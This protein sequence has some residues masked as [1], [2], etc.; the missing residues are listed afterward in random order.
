MLS[1][2]KILFFFL[3]Q[4]LFEKQRE[5]AEITHPLAHSANVLT[6]QGWAR[7]QDSI[8][9]CLSLGDQT[10]AL[11]PLSTDLYQQEAGLELEQSMVRAV[12]FP[13]GN[14]SCRTHPQP[15]YI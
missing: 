1:L 6:N 8:Q 13:H 5:I 9:A 3:F 14:L 4:V 7:T 12:G 10:Q 15:I 2:F 11:E